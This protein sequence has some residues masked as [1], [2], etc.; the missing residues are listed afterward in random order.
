MPLSFFSWNY[1]SAC[2]PSVLVNLVAT[3]FE[4]V[5]RWQRT[6]FFVS[7]RSRSGVQFFLTYW[8]PF[9]MFMSQLPVSCRYFGCNFTSAKTLFGAYIYLTSNLD[10]IKIYFTCWLYLCNSRTHQVSTKTSSIFRTQWLVPPGCA[11]LYSAFLLFGLD[12]DS[13]Q[14]TIIVP[15]LHSSVHLLNLG[16]RNCYILLLHHGLVLFIEPCK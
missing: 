3:H 10:D 7:C 11:A 2:G 13:W 1:S 6:N 15:L 16:C 14:L 9:I 4:L 12:I 8:F 5:T